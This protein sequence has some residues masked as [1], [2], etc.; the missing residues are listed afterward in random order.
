MLIARNEA[1]RS[2]KGVTPLSCYV[3]ARQRHHPSR[4]KKADAVYLNARHTCNTLARSLARTPFLPAAIRNISGSPCEPAR[5]AVLRAA[6]LDEQIFCPSPY[7]SADLRPP[8]SA[9]RVIAPSDRFHAI[10]QKRV[11]A[12]RWANAR[13]PC[14]HCRLSVTGGIRSN[15]DVLLWLFVVHVYSTV[16]RY[17][18]RTFR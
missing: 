10:A 3:C 18:K 6:G 14:A 15:F 16:E 1:D 5:A 2:S 13:A 4:G 11:I 9:W 7:P 17:V 12:G 8:Q